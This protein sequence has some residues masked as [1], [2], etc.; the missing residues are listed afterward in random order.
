MGLGISPGAWGTVSTGLQVGGAA[1]SVIGAIG[2]AAGSRHQASIDDTNARLSTLAAEAA[3]VQGQH[4]EQVSR[5]QYADV[6]SKQKVAFASNGVDP[7]SE[8]AQRAF[9]TTDYLGELDANTIRANAVR[10]SFGYRAQAVGY[11]NRALAERAVNPAMAG[12]GTLLGSGAQVA[13]S[14]YTLNKGGVS[15]VTPIGPAGHDPMD[16]I[17]NS[18]GD[19]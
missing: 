8:S 9:T 7:T 3:V 10:A 15:A 4:E 5:L 14:W 16:G 18:Y 2:S 12:A 6:K 1:T 13:R 19:Y 17:P 11:G